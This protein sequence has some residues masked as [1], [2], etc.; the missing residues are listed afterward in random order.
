MSMAPNSTPLDVYGMD[1]YGPKLDF[2]LVRT[3]REIN[4]LDAEL[5]NI[6]SAQCFSLLLGPEHIERHVFNPTPTK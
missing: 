3:Y 2:V 6:S 1:V 4:T 5:M